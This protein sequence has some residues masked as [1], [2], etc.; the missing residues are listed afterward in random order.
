ML[1]SLCSA[2]AVLLCS[3]VSGQEFP[4]AS[5]KKGLQV[6]MLDDALALGVKHATLNVNLSSFAVPANAKNSK[7]VATYQWKHDGREFR[8]RKSVVDDFDRKIAKLS[9]NDVLVYLILLVYRS[10]DPA[11]NEVLCHPKYDS[12]APN[13]LSAFNTVTEDGQQW[14]AA[15]TEFMADR[16][17]PRLGETET[18][19]R[20]VGYIVGNEVNSHWFWSN[21]GS[22]TMPEF[23]KDYHAAVRTVHRAVRKTA[24]WPRVYVS[25]EHHWNIRFAGGNGMQAFPGR[26]FLEELSRLVKAEGDFDWHVA[27]HPYPENLR[28]PRFWKDRSATD[29]DDSPRITFR[30]LQVLARFLERP[31]MKFK[32]EPRRVILSEQG[33]DT[34]AGDDGETVQAAAY[35]YAYRKVASMKNI[36]AFILH[37][38]VDHKYEGGLRLGLWSR[39]P[40]SVSSPDRKKKIY[41]CFKAADQDDWEDAFRFALPIVNL[42]SW[43]E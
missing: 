28:N 27:F 35:C 36:D 22:V 16:W 11:I 8:F 14:L 33:F 23:A 10:A 19:P 42:T 18:R 41:D 20:V 13:R 1:L 43:E 9:R 30:N 34:P 7:D 37:R 40:D 25:L 12:A 5:S 24:A 32:G 4:A 31:E 15:L 29:A 17:T 21:R 3:P 38:H 39:K 6:Q 26:P 2:F